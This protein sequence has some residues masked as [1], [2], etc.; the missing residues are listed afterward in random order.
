LFGPVMSGEKNSEDVNASLPGLTRQSTSYKPNV[1]LRCA[2]LRASLGRNIVI[3]GLSRQS[4]SYKPKRHPE[5]RAL[6]RL[7][8]WLRGLR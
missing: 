2:H 3:A 7:E 5:V 8:G 1:I 4:T 6:A